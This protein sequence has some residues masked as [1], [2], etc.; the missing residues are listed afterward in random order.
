[1]AKLEA[2]NQKMKEA[3]EQVKGQKNKDDKAMDEMDEEFQELQKNTKEA[4]LRSAHR[5]AYFHRSECGQ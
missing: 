4:M 5:S 2:L 3:M 1:M